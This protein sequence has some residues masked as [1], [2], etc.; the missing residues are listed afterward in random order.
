M[1]YEEVKVVDGAVDLHPFQ[2]PDK[3]GHFAQLVWGSTSRI[4]CGMVIFS[5]P[6]YGECMKLTCNYFPAGNYMG[7]DVY[8]KRMSEE[9]ACDQPGLIESKKYKGLCVKDEDGMGEE[10]ITQVSWEPN[11]DPDSHGV[12]SQNELKEYLEFEKQMQDLVQQS[13]AG[14]NTL[15]GH[16]NMNSLETAQKGY[17]TPRQAL[18]ENRRV[19]EAPGSQYE[20]GPLSE[21]DFA[22]KQK[23]SSSLHIRVFSSTVCVHNSLLTLPPLRYTSHSLFLLFVAQAICSSSPLCR[24]HSLFFLLGAQASSSVQKPFALPPSR[25]TSHLLF[26][27]L[28]AQAIRSS[29]SSVHRPFALPPPL[30]TGH[31]LF[32][33]LCAQAICSSSSSVHRPF[34]LPPLCTDHSLLPVPG[35]QSLTLPPSLPKGP[36]TR[37]ASFQRHSVGSNSLQYVQQGSTQCVIHCKGPHGHTRF[38]QH[39][40]NRNATERTRN[41]TRESKGVNFYR[42]CKNGYCEFIS[43][44]ESEGDESG[45]LRTQAVKQPTYPQ[46]KDDQYGPG[47]TAVLASKHQ[48]DL[49]SRPVPIPER[50]PVLMQVRSPTTYEVKRPRPDHQHEIHSAQQ[51]FSVQHPIPFRT[52]HHIPELKPLRTQHHTPERKP[53]RSQ[54]DPSGVKPFRARDSIPEPE[55]FRTQESKQDL[56]P[57]RNQDD[58]SELDPFRGQNPTSELTA[59]TKD[60]TMDQEPFRIQNPIWHQQQHRFRIQDSIQEQNPFYIEYD[61]DPFSVQ[62]RYQKPLNIRH[63][64]Q[65]NSIHEQE[66]SSSHEQRP[67][68]VRKHEP[69]E[70]RYAAESKPVPSP[71]PQHEPTDSIPAPDLQYQGGHV[72][73]GS[74]YPRTPK[75]SLDMERDRIKTFQSHRS[76]KASS[77]TTDHGPKSKESQRASKPVRNVW[78]N[79]TYMHHIPANSQYYNFFQN[80][81]PPDVKHSLQKQGVPLVPAK[82]IFDWYGRRWFPGGP[83][84]PTG[85]QAIISDQMNDLFSK[86][87][88]P[89]DINEMTEF[90]GN[91]A[92]KHGN[93]VSFLVQLLSMVLVICYRRGFQTL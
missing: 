68:P 83:H 44:H 12:G 27:L 69:F 67:H 50:K 34:A 3:F 28:C 51:H 77:P 93:T 4:G 89:N 71:A 18:T 58:I 64:A 84:H 38:A 81:I 91:T 1:F 52:Q 72:K 22:N 90:L 88:Y 85:S 2:L 49:K 53:F 60:A 92:S 30:C 40:L 74:F 80:L 78:T 16:M 42:E 11:P 21:A 46:L 39:Y 45:W 62:D 87:A 63:N 36:M 6:L 59:Y 76:R 47:Y 32:L 35:N 73:R 9:K 17:D 19:F 86:I 7:E 25:C 66:P 75:P 26:L 41:Q 65:S 56:K 31:S 37:G 20:N 82:T 5:C 14:K 13:G 79:D 61:D 57:F 70:S 15:Y 23:A 8:E 24:S 54:E 10:T 43:A 29:S 33:L 48:L 55:P